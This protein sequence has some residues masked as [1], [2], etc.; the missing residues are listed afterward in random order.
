MVKHFVGRKRK[1]D[2][3]QHF[4]SCSLRRMKT[5]S[6][7]LN[8]VGV[9]AARNALGVGADRMRIA[10]KADKLPASWYDTLERLAGRPLPRDVFTFKGRP[11]AE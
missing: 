7:I 3:R 5:P 9:D 11:A 8:F 4:F 10:Q 6:E 2:L 1:T